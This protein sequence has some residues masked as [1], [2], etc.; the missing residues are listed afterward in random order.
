M[1]AFLYGNSQEGI[2]QTL[3]RNKQACPAFEIIYLMQRRVFSSPALYH[4][5]SPAQ[6]AVMQT[7]PQPTMVSQY[8]YVRCVGY[9]YRYISKKESPMKSFYVIP[10]ML[11]LLAVSSPGFAL[12]KQTAQ[13]GT[14]ATNNPNIIKYNSTI[15]AQ[16]LAGRPDSDF[17]EFSNGR[18]LRVRDIRRLQTVQQK[19]MAANPGRL[20]P[21][22]L[23]VKPA[24]KGRLLNTQ[25]DIVA[26]LKRPDSETVQLPSGRLVTVG[27]IKFV[28]PLVEKRL[29]RSLTQIKQNNLEGPAI[30]IT[31]TTTKSEWVTILRMPDS[32]VL[33]SPNGKRITLGKL[34]QEMTQKRK[35]A[36]VKTAPA[37][38]PKQR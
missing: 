6:S 35:I 30:K 37:L 38:T 26:A 1:A 12:D 18:R 32:T 25:A 21:A 2:V 16:S 13:S 36:P 33:E 3:H 23:K 9:I 15:T 17:V 14:A 28:Q 8:F 5:P 11:L 27:Q 10:M 20:L 7:F 29:G 4:H 31:K 22:A 19:M 34:K 24:S